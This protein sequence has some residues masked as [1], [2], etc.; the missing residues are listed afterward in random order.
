MVWQILHDL[1]EKSLI[2]AGRYSCRS[3]AFTALGTGALGYPP[4][5]VSRI[6]MTTIADY[7]EQAH[8]SLEIVKIVIFHDKEME[9]VR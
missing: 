4:E 8:S 5:I 7:L 2:T 3:L 1:V 9:L 6:M